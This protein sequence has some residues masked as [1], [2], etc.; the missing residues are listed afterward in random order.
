VLLV[1][2]NA[3]NQRVAR[4]ILERLGC[5]VEVVYDGAEAVA[6]YDKQAYSIVL[7]DM[8]M[9]VMDGLEA[10]RRRRFPNEPSAGTTPRQIR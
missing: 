10:T 1:E 9:P 8:Q 6:A 7:M 2:D 4:R 5:A 3:V